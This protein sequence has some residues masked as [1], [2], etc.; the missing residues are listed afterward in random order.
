MPGITRDSIIL[1]DGTVIETGKNPRKVY[2][3]GEFFQQDRLVLKSHAEALFDWIKA[4]KDHPLAKKIDFKDQEDFF[5]RTEF[6]KMQEAQ[7]AGLL[8]R[9]KVAPGGKVIVQGDPKK[10]TK[11]QKG[12]H[13]RMIHLRNKS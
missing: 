13:W 3:G 6:D 2:E 1:S 11:A 9:V 12:C 8:V 10:L 4:N 5:E 7:Q